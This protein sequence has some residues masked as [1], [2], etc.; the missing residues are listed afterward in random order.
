[1][2]SYVLPW[3]LVFFL[4]MLIIAVV[5]RR[6][7][8]S[9]MLATPF[10]IIGFT[11]APLFFPNPP[12]IPPPDSFPLKIM[13]YNLHGI[14]EIDGIVE[15]IRREKPDILLIQEYSKKLVSPSFHG[16]DDLYPELYVEVASKDFGQATFSRYPIELISAELEKGRT[17]KMQ[18]ETPAGSI[19]VWNVHPIPP[20]LIPPEQYDAQVSALVTD[21]SQTEGP[22]IMA[23]DLNATD[24]SEVYRTINRYL[25]DAYWEAGWGFGF[26]YPAPPYTFMD[27]PLQTGPLWRIDH[28]FHDQ[29][30]IA[31]NMR[32]L[33]TSGGSDHFPVVAELSIVK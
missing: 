3:L 23:G 5:A 27:L 26:G 18:I 10:L 8:L 19:E 20:Y 31:I 14:K 33:K 11:F 15:V 16:L 21:I 32:T 24:Q 12:I 30:F 25:Q 28:V 29:H 13:S 2:V 4:P 22:L 9:F 6:K 7:L 1:M 17:Q